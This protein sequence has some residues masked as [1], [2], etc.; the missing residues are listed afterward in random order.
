ML[1]P[2][3]TIP[4]S[5]DTRLLYLLNILWIQLQN[6]AWIYLAPRTDTVS[7]NSDCNGYSVSAVIQAS[8]TVVSNRTLKEGDLMSQVSLQYDCC[9]VWDNL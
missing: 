6:N 8:S 5:Y 9:E 4:K 1:K 7:D 2:R 3:C